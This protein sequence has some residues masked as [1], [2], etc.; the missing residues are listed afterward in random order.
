MLDALL[1]HRPGT[2]EALDLIEAIEDAYG[3][4]V[5]DSAVAKF[6]QYWEFEAPVVEP[7]KKDRSGLRHTGQH[8]GQRKCNAAA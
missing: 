4:E 7:S 5:A 1:R 8:S 6:A 3:P 2:P